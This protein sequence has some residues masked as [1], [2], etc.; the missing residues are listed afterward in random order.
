MMMSRYR[1]A[2]LLAGAL[3]LVAS[4]RADAQRGIDTKIF[5]PALDSY[6]I[7]SVERAQTSHQWDFGFKLYLDYAS[8]PLRLNMF[9]PASNKPKTSNMIDNLVTLNFGAHLGLTDWLEGAIV[10][11]VSAQSFTD[12]YGNYG[13]EDDP[14][15]SRTGFYAG[16]PYTNVPPPNASPGDVRLALKARLFRK[17]I[18]GMALIA[19]ITVPFGDDAAF[20]GDANFTFRPML[21]FDVTRGPITFAINLGAIVRE[22]T[23]VYDPYD[24]AA[25][26]A[27]PRILLDLSHELTWSAGLAYRF[28][29]WV[30]IAAEV[31]GY[32]PLVVKAGAPTDRTADVLGG[33]Q[34]FPTKDVV[35]NVGAGADVFP[36]AYRHDDFR[37]FLGLN[38]APAEGQKGAISASGIDSDGDGIPD[39]V[40][41]C[42]NQPEDHDGFQDDDG[43]PDPD[44]DGD[45]IP[46]KLDKC[47]NEPE[48]KD[49][50]QDE[51][52]CPDVDNDGDGIPDAQDKCPNDPEDRDGFQDDDGCP[53][54]DNDGDG[55]PD[56]VDKC[57]NEPETRNGIDDEDGCPDSGGQAL[58]AGRIEIKEVVG[59]DAQKTTLTKAGASELDRIAERLKSNPQVKRVRIEGHADKSE[60]KKA[61]ALSQGRADAA[62]E[63]LIKKGVEAE[64]L[65][66]VGY[67]DSRP[68]AT[69]T[70]ADARA[71][72]RRVEFIV[73]EQ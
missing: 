70:T 28:V 31:Y 55:I 7:F 49:G 51:D 25:K 37:V 22:E 53:D 18:V 27:K 20:L 24:V 8:N 11:P 69:G 60:G 58:P 38:W 39:G 29:H 12:A 43:C 67:G 23:T 64:R 13:H 33:L 65:Q 42:P 63:Y 32:E 46:D 44:N 10:V 19:G 41:Q 73:V 66:A 68:F 62:R 48:D 72:N 21:V 40:D 26:V 34:L 5:L 36:S 47:P 9:D 59:F 35:I 6:G 1:R 45:G 50:F 57:P 14:M 30:G 56:A 2:A 15:I 54:A 17:N 61:F 52:G 4:G 16:S 3:L 71:K